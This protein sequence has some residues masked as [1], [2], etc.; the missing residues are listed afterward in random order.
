M[1]QRP[2]P[3]AS[4]IAA[5]ESQSIAAGGRFLPARGSARSCLPQGRR[6]RAVIAST[7]RK[8]IHAHRLPAVRVEIDEMQRHDARRRPT[9][10]PTS[11]FVRSP[12]E[13]RARLALEA[14]RRAERTA[15]QAQHHDR[16]RRFSPPRTRRE[17]APQQRRR[18]RA[19]P[20]SALGQR[21]QPRAPPRSRRRPSGPEQAHVA[22]GGRA[23]TSASRPQ[24]HCAR[25]P[26]GLSA[27][28]AGR[29]ALPPS[30]SAVSTRRSGLADVISWL[31]LPTA[32]S[33]LVHCHPVADALAAAGE[34]LRIAGSRSVQG[35]HSALPAR[36]ETLEDPRRRRV[37]DDLPRHR[38]LARQQV[39]RSPTSAPP[40]PRRAPTSA[41]PRT[42]GHSSPLVPWSRLSRTGAGQPRKRTTCGCERCTRGTSGAA[43][44]GRGSLARPDRARCCCGCTPAVSTSPTRCWRPGATR[45]S[46]RSPS[47]PAR[48]LRRGRGG[49]RPGW[50]APAPGL[51]VA[52]LVRLGRARRVS[53]RS[54]PP[55]ACRSPS[56]MPDEEAAGFPVAYGTSHVALA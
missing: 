9:A 48:G 1:V 35:D 2:L 50:Q 22:P 8:R 15:H 4:P 41:R 18:R 34:A 43:R 19:V 11:M 14:D 45:R 44:A 16:E 24:V 29:R 3:A 46:P 37:D 20:L 39:G 54:R 31:P 32:A 38:H 13:L 47:R 25:R 10:S 52:C 12:A 40:T 53:S 56:A 33:S 49:L 42:H 21:L 6:H 30:S 36:V 23:P 27:S 55:A 17:H 28:Q 5:A 7:S 51:A 26:S